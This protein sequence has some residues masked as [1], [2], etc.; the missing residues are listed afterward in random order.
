MTTIKFYIKNIFLLSLAFSALAACTTAPEST[1]NTIPPVSIQN[2][3]TDQLSE[4]NE[5]TTTTTVDT[6]VTTTVPQTTIPTSATVLDCSSVDLTK[7][8]SLIPDDW[9]IWCQSFIDT[10]AIMSRYSGSELVNVCNEFVGKADE[11]IVAEARLD[12][13]ITRDQAIGLIDS[14]WIVCLS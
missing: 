4:N 7:T 12:Y 6:V 14:L 1:T 3:T 10:I 2:E 11:D 9:D 13:N 5:Q 8:S